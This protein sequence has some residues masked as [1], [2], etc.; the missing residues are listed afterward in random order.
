MKNTLIL[1]LIVLIGTMTSILFGFASIWICNTIHINLFFIEIA[2]ILLFDIG[3]FFVLKRMSTPK[4]LTGVCA[5]VPSIVLCSILSG[6]YN[7][8]AY[9]A[10]Y[11]EKGEI[12]N[13]IYYSFSG[14]V[15]IS[16]Y[17]AVIFAFISAF[18]YLLK[19]QKE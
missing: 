2:F 1:F 7:D 16:I 11:T 10:N 9:Q 18:S 12:L 13:D 3:S 8:L 5:F 19:T 17:A 4:W 15:M 6:H 14:A